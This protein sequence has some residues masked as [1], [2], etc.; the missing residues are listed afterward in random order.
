MFFVN[1][2]NLDLQLKEKEKKKKK[3]YDIDELLPRKK[4]A[5]K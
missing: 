3:P 5:F 4:S 2:L 1:S